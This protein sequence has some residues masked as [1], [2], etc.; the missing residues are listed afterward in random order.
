MNPFAVVVSCEGEEDQIFRGL[1]E[2]DVQADVHNWLLKKAKSLSRP[3]E[4]F[5][6]YLKLVISSEEELPEVEFYEHLKGTELTPKLLRTGT[7]FSFRTTYKES[8]L[9][10]DRQYSYMVL[11]E[12]GRAL[13]ELFGHSEECMNSSE[14]LLANSGL[15][16]RTFPP[17]V[18][19]EDV[20]EAV[21]Q[22][23][24]NLSNKGVGHQDLHAGNVLMG[25]D[26]SLRLIDFEYAGFL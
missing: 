13:D 16:D 3:L 23:L 7:L 10:F 22:L 24:E 17:A 20:R 25:D 2:F 14:E 4:G 26:G 6:E 1:D 15:F 19:P 18:F 5:G 9:V 8:G 21:K 11:E 12:F